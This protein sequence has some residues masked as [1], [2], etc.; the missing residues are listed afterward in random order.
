MYKRLYSFLQA[1][2]VLY[3]YQFGFQKL[4]SALLQT[5]DFIYKHL[6]IHMSVIVV[7]LDL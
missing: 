2:D 7:Y 1:N 5:A 3:K 6:D 4:H